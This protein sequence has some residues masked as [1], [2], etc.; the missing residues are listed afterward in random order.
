MLPLIGTIRRNTYSY[1]G[2][3]YIDHI[4]VY[5]HLS[6]RTETSRS[7]CKE[8]AIVPIL[9]DTFV[10]QYIYS[11]APEWCGS[12]FKS[13]ILEFILQNSSW[14]ISC[15][16]ALRWM[17]QKSF[18]DESTLVLVMACCRQAGNRL[19]QYWLWLMLPCGVT[20]PSCVKMIWW[21][22]HLTFQVRV[23][24]LH[25]Q[26]SACRCVINWHNSD[27]N[28]DMFSSEIL[29]LSKISRNFL[30]P[31]LRMKITPIS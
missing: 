28:L 21:F 9:L 18:D 8:S 1:G 25:G 30:P 5:M 24:C 6:E 19:S 7:N 15:E 17:Q 14:G 10:F 2:N 23:P 22:D 29:L 27:Y 4:H 16:F 11:L 31:L 26:H 20:R 12:N 3:L 13:I